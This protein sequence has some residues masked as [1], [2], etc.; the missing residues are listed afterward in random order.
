[1]SL[2]KKRVSQ[3]YGSGSHSR[4]LRLAS[5]KSV[6]L[7]KIMARCSKWLRLKE[8]GSPYLPQKIVP[9]EMAIKYFSNA[10]VTYFLGSLALLEILVGPLLSQYG[11]D[12]MTIHVVRVRMFYFW[13][14]VYPFIHYRVFTPKIRYVFFKK[15]I[16]IE[17]TLI[18]VV[19]LL[20]F[21]IR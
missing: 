19:C 6:N 9:Q 7:K 5:A 18:Q 15:L 21:V 3:A 17:G 12:Q 14:F 8:D 10:V 1:M 11:I 20:D 4:H 2:A 13:A 16:R